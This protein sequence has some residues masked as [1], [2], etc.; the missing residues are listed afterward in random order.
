MPGARDAG[1]V[2]VGNGN[3]AMIPPGGWWGVAVLLVLTLALDI[4]EDMLQ[5]RWARQRRERERD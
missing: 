4:A 1:T 5:R 3:D 2:A